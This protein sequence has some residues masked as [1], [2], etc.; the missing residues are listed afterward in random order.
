MYDLKDLKYVFFDLDGTVTDPKEGITKSVKYSLKKFGIE[1]EDLNSLCPFIGPPL[2]QSYE[3]FYDF[4]HEKALEAVDEY[5][6]YY[7]DRGIFE[8]F[9]YD[10]IKELVK[11][12]HENGVKVILATSKPEEFARQILK[13]FDILKYFDIVA[14]S[15]M[16]GSRVEKVDVIRHAISQIS[17]FDIENAVMVGDRKFD[18]Y[19]ANE[20]GMRCILIS[21]GYGEMRELKECN[22]FAIIDSVSELHKFLDS[23]KKQG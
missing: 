11:D 20:C 15:T 5:R 9:L 8:C 7:K 6:V 1:V 4:S 22:P 2:S 13:H 12:L 18:Y 16:D 21:Y 10:G 23:I 3:K 14:G 19:G 17:D